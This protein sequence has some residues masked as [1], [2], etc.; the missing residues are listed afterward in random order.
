MSYNSTHVRV[1]IKNH[2]YQEQR[3]SQPNEKRKSPGANAKMIQMLEL[4]DQDF[5]AAVIKM[6]Q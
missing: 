2:S 6:L 4:S 3:R 5:K 1:S